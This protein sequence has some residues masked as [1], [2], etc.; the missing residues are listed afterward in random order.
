MSLA[1]L[2]RVLIEVYLS[3]LRSQSK[4]RSLAIVQIGLAVLVLVSTIALFPFAGVNAV[5]YGLLFSEL[6]VAILIFGNLRKI[7]KFDETGK[8][9]V[10]QGSSGTA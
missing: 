7:L 6:L 10:I 9:T 8:A 5:G 1:V 2:P 3:A 4:A